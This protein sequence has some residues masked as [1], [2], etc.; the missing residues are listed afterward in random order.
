MKI[1]L[2]QVVRVLLLT[3]IVVGVIYLTRALGASHL[4]HEGIWDI[5]IFSSLVGVGVAGL[6]MYFVRRGSDQGIVNVFLA[7]TVFRMLLSI[8]FITL[9]FF[10]GLE[11]EVVWIG[12]FFVVYLFYLVF[13]IYS[14]ISNLR[15]ISNEGEKQ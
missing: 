11:N 12:D 4:V 15:A 2:Q 8:I 3:A 13:E 7:T 1:F 10:G 14:I 6:N 9:N 5:I